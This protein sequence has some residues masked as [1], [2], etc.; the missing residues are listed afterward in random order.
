MLTRVSTVPDS[1]FGDE[2]YLRRMDLYTQFVCHQLLREILEQ[3]R[4]R[5][6]VATDPI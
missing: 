3:E 4:V 1:A 5:M 2:I 6:A